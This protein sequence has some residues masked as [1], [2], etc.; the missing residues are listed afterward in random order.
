MAIPKI[1]EQD[2]MDALKYIDENGVPF[3]NQS[4]KYE[5]VTEGGRKYPPKYVI[6]VAAHIANGS[7]ISTEGFNAVEA[8]SYLQGKGYN[9]ETKQEKFELVITAESTES[10]DERFT[11]DN[12]SLGDNYKPLDVYF[13]KADGEVIKRDYAKGERRN[14]NQ[15]MPRIACQLYEKQLAGL[16]IEEKESFPVCKYNPSSDMISGIFSLSLI[17]I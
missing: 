14:S 11:M 5:L 6:A 1:K 8:K 10:T 16:S 3:H 2:I 17:H 12:L 9:I 4:T 13:K 7:S 15:T